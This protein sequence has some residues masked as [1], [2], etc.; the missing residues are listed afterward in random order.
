[1]VLGLVGGDAAEPLPLIALRHA[2]PVDVGG[3]EGLLGQ[4]LRGRRL[5]D[6]LEADGVNQP[7]VLQDQLR[8]PLLCYNRPAGSP[9]PPKSLRSASPAALC[10]PTPIIR[11]G[12]C[13]FF[14]I[15]EKIFSSSRRE[16]GRLCPNL[17]NI[18]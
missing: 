11:N 17:F 7:L 10:R 14:K 18:E 1:M 5:P 15:I 16:E 9:P 2:L 6:Q 3:E 13:E 4:V 12:A 8:K